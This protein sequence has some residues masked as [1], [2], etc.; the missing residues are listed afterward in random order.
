MF[1][2]QASAMLRESTE[3]DLEAVL[4][5][6]APGGADDLGDA[7]LPECVAEP[8]VLAVDLDPLVFGVGVG[9]RF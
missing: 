7:E 2:K 5:D 9:M 1:N 3:A 8:A 6:E 4:V